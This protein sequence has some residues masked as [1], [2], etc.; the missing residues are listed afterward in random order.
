MPTFLWKSPF[1]LFIAWL[2]CIAHATAQPKSGAPG[3]TALSGHDEVVLVF[4]TDIMSPANEPAGGDWIGYHI[5]RKLSGDGDFVRI[6]AKPVSHVGSLQELEQRLGISVD[7]LAS[8]MKFSS[9]AQLWNA[10]EKGDPKLVRLSMLDPE[11][12]EVLGLLYRDRDVQRGT[13]YTYL[14]TKV[15][16]GGNESERSSPS[17]VTF[18]EPRFALLGPIDV[19]VTAGENSVS[20]RWNLNPLD[21]GAFS[22]SVYRANDP[23]GYFA[24]MNDAPILLFRKKGAASFQNASFRD[25]SVQKNLTYY[26]SVV[27]VD[28]AGNES[29]RQPLYKATPRDTTPPSIPQEVKARSS[30]YGIALTWKKD[31][32]TDILGYNVYRSPNADG[33]YELLNTSLVPGDTCIYED[34]K[35]KP[36]TQYF[37]RVTAVDRSGNESAQSAR[38]MANFQNFRPPLP[39]VGV[40]AK[41]SGKQIT[42]RWKANGEDDL[43]GY[44]VFRSEQFN[45]DLVQISPLIRKDTTFY[46]DADPRLSPKGAYWYIVQAINL[47]GSVS[48]FSAPAISAPEFT[49]GPAAPTSVRGFQDVI[50]NRIFWTLPNDNTVKGL[51]IYRAVKDKNPQWELLHGS[52]FP[53]NLGSTTDSSAK[54]GISYLY[55]I[56]SVNPAGKEGQPSASITLERFAPPPIAPANINVSRSPQGVKISWDPSMQSRIRGYNVYRKRAAGPGV[57]LNAEMLPVHARGFVDTG[58][59]KGTRYYYTMTCVGEDDRESSHSKPVMIVTP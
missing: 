20:L 49:D 24:R 57:K 3:V 44:F 45:G 6:T 25:T 23:G 40:T 30:G 32:G 29:S 58:A 37:Y 1:L 34:T 50:G 51:N 54:L 52:P 18:G 43:Q 35:T 42:I 19:K 15:K 53:P 31:R 2:A 48:S 9:R 13:T 16:A 39:P 21:S 55:H 8:T 11:L 38:S 41:A 28:Y 12:R 4:G 17:T 5:Y 47:S 26:Y 33:P 14:V 27:S 59:E 7:I 36:N 22:F 10:I 56:R 46:V